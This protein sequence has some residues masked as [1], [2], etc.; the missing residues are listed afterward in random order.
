MNI[1]VTNPTSGKVVINTDSVR[2][3]VPATSGR[4]IVFFNSG[5]R[6]EVEESIDQIESMLKNNAATVKA[7]RNIRKIK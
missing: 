3:Y 4:T 2:I 6:L 5:E 7:V 1:T